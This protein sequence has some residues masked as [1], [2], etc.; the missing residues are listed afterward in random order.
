VRRV[1]IDCHCHAGPGDGLSGPWDTT[2]PLGPYLARARAAGIDGT[3]FFAVF[4]SDY[5]VANRA[6]AGIVAE[7]PRRRMGFAFVHAHRDRGRIE[8]LVAEGVERHGFRGIKVHRHD[9]RIT[10]EI[11]EVARRYRLPVLYDVMGETSMVELLAIE[12]PDV[13]FV[14]PHLGSFMDD[15]RAQIALLDPLVRH[16]NIHTDS[17]GVRR[18]DLLAQAVRRA[19]PRKVLFGSDGPWL[20]P[21]IELHKIRMLGL[22]PSSARLVLGENL[23]RL[24]ARA[25]RRP[26]GRVSI[27]P[28]WASGPVAPASASRPVAPAGASS[29][30]APAWASSAVAPAWASSPPSRPDGA[31]PWESEQFPV[32]G[33]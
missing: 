4:H 31:D 19:G 22:A 5:A 17:S 18:F 10:G 26:R 8:G 2:A 13:D 14:I 21:G 25:R 3:V 27:A 32:G 20:H 29:A 6:V 12:Y 15:W 24:T 16:P 28:G 11:C 23:L 30:V 1:I 33:R 9:A 7:D